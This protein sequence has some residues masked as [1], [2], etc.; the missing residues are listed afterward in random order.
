LRAGRRAGY[1]PYVSDL[2]TR[3][4][5]PFRAARDDLREF[6]E[7]YRAAPEPSISWDVLGFRSAFRRAL[8]VLLKEHSGPGRM[9]LAVWLG[10]VVGCTPLYGIHY[11]IV[12]VLAVFLR[13]NKLVTWLATNVSFPAFAPFVAFF[14]VQAGSLVTT[15]QFQDLSLQVLIDSNWADLA[16]RFFTLWLI[17]GVFVGA[18]LGAI[19]AAPVYWIL[20]RREATTNKPA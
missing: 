19:L 6:R 5:A 18:V 1:K 20:A 9:A 11:V 15:G 16:R 8:P 3:L 17:G 2:R 14:S 10:T 4:A 12:I 13:L 7:A